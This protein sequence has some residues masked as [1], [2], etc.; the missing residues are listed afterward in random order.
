MNFYEKVDI[1]NN[2]V[3]Y[4]LKAKYNDELTDEETMEIETLH[5]YVRKIK[6]SEIDFTSNVTMESGTPTVTENEL[7]DTV[8]E[9]TLGKIAPKE[10]VLDENI[11]ISFS[12]DAGRIPDS[13]LNDVL[14]TKPLVSQAK[15]AVFKT[16]LMEKVSE[17][18][19]EIRNEDN[20]FE[21]ETE[22]I[23]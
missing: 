20:A 19:A 12:I 4:V 2:I 16:K 17:I 18:L 7:S 10:Y 15:I 1:E 6:F 3:K 11:N 9:V 14:T 22:T 5:D 13:E 21:Q 23:L 8:V